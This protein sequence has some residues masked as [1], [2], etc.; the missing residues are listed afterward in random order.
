MP[1]MYRSM[2]VCLFT[3]YHVH[4]IAISAKGESIYIFIAVGFFKRQLMQ[5]ERELVTSQ[6]YFMRKRVE[7]SWKT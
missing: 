3:I 7:F 2:V 1:C 4:C 6:T 5:I